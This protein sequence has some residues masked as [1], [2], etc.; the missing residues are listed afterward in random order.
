MEN[1]PN[2]FVRVLIIF[3]ALLLGG[4]VG[5][6]FALGTPNYVI[7]GGAITVILIITV[8]ILS[9][10]FNNLSIGKLLSISKQIVEK[11]TQNVNLKEENKEL[12]QHFIQ[13]TSMLNNQSQVTTN[14]NGVSTDALRQLFGV[15]PIK[16]ED[17]EPEPEEQIVHTVSES[18]SQSEDAIKTI[19][20]H[21]MLRFAEK[22]TLE[23]HFNQQQIP[24]N[25]I[26][27]DVQFTPA[28]QGLDPI[29]ER[30]ISFDGYYKLGNSEVFIEVIRKQVLHSIRLDRLYVMLSKILYYRQAKNV[31]AKLVVLLMDIPDLRSNSN[32]YNGYSVEKFL[33]V[34]QPAI[35]NNLLRVET[36]KYS[37]EDIELYT[38]EAAASSIKNS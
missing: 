26:Q 2:W 1:K 15:T 18:N 10:A 25:I 28:F 13:I 12:R 27:Y 14:I 9:E 5:V 31:E 16:E 11:E 23:R 6:N 38:K 33:E 17:K 37:Q 30:P 4:M 22:E 35:A 21:K 36:M 3:Y 24:L 20:F 7:T 32:G 19:N 29:M 8:M 34:F